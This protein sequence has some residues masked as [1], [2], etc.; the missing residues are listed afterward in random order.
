MS[1]PILSA[2]V[3]APSGG[4]DSLGEKLT[5]DAV[6]KFKLT[7]RAVPKFADHEL[8][9]RVGVPDFRH[10]LVNVVRHTGLPAA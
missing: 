10:H 2:L 4:H 8:P 6:L 5:T 9:I 7:A 3:I 1:A